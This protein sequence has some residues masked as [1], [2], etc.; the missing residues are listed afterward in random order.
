MMLGYFDLLVPRN[1][2]D[3]KVLKTAIN[4]ENVMTRF[5]KDKDG[6][7][8]RDEAKGHDILNRA[9]PLEIPTGWLPR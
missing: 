3:K 8:S 4:P 6:K 2:T 5:D 7:I 9:F 1:L